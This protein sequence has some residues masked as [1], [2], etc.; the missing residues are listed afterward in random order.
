MRTNGTMEVA[1]KKMICVAIVLTAGILACGAEV[2]PPEEVD[3]VTEPLTVLGYCDVS[4]ATG[5]L[6]GRCRGCA[7]MCSTAIDPECP[8]GSTPIQTVPYR[9]ICGTVRFDRGRR[10]T[11]WLSC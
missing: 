7:S 4:N 5:R 3:E 8:A 1:M 11:A 10:C 2:T 9:A 6:T